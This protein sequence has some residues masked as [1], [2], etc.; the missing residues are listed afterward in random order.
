MNLKFTIMKT[1]HSTTDQKDR[2]TV[3]H[4]GKLKFIKL[5]VIG[6]IVAAGFSSCVVYAHPAHPY[7]WHHY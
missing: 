5:L 7:Y 3:S 4:T 1:L 6:L 2:I